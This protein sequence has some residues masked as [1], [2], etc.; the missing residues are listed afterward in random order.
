MVG[1]VLSGKEV[2]DEIKAKLK[3]QVDDIRANDESFRPGLVI[4]QVFS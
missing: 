4:V 2:S 1:V 3:N